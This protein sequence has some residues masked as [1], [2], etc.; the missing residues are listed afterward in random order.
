MASFLA[1]VTE[2]IQAY[3]LINMTNVEEGQPELSPAVD[4]D[5]PEFHGQHNLNRSEKK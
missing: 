1:T 5:T 4:G 2:N 3:R